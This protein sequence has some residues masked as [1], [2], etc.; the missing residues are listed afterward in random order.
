M[1]GQFKTQVLEAMKDPPTEIRSQN[2][3]NFAQALRQFSATSQAEE[4]MQAAE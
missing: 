3:Q 2:L 1:S 4:F